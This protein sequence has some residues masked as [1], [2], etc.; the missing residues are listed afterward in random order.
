VEAVREVEKER[1]YDDQ[2]EGE[3]YGVHRS[4]SMGWRECGADG[5]GVTNEQFT[6]S[7]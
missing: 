6:V 7:S 3:G 5:I 4:L 2:N 1:Q